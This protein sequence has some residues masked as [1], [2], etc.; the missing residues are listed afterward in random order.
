MP[1]PRDILAYMRTVGRG[2]PVDRPW[3]IAGQMLS[4]LR[5]G[6]SHAPEGSPLTLHDIMASPDYRNLMT[7]KVAEGDL[8]P[9]FELPRVDGDSFVRLSTLL[10]EKPVALVFGSYT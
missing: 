7:A 6:S 2:S 10:D 9:D 4:N 8:A 3:S 5:L 1:S